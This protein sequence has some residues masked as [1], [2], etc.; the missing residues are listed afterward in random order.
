M[1]MTEANLLM[2]LMLIS[3]L[4]IAQTP[5]PSRP[6]PPPDPDPVNITSAADTL[7]AAPSAMISNGV[8]DAT[9]ALPD[10]DKGFYR[11]TRF[12]W[13][14]VIA[15]LTYG[16]QEY[17]G[18]WFDQKAPNIRDFVFH[19]GKVVAGPQTSAVGPV[20]AYD[21]VG[22]QDA[23]V[24]GTFVKVGV[25]VMRKPDDQPYS[26]YRS[27][28]IIDH[29]KWEVKT[30]GQQVEMTQTV[31]DPASGY[32]FIYRKVV[33][34]V[35]GRPVMELRCSLTNTGT[36]PFVTETFNHNFL[37]LGGAPTG[38]GLKVSAGHAIAANT[39]AA[40]TAE[41]SGNTL[42][43]K[44]ALVGEERFSNALTSATPETDSYDFSVTN[45]QGAGYHVTSTYP[46]LRAMLWSMV[47][48]VAVEPRVKIDLAPGKSAEWTFSYTYSLP[49]GSA[50][51]AT[52]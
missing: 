4:A 19:Q 46:L 38:P 21:A 37:T 24:G 36:K 13:A 22:F 12:D 25:G 3:T 27:Y 34:L 52:N 15:S 28:E 20:D 45:A 31:S 10:K 50:G 14:G 42:T 39:P 8:L 29:G 18:L 44:R 7:A 41:V 49:S 11:G 5:A 26:Q 2:G 33:H 17:Y 1:R 35:P 30:T 23:A 6:A 16:G 40:N 47:R 32:G 48:T 9:I 43:Y 51:A